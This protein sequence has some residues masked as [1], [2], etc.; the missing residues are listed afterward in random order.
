VANGLPQPGGQQR[1]QS[2]F[3]VFENFEK[4][5]TQSIRQSLSEKELAWLENLQPIA[6]NNLTT[7]PAPAAVALANI[8][9][10]TTLEFYADMN[11]TD[12]FIVFNTAGAAFAVNLDTGTVNNF[13]ASGTFSTAPDVTTWQASRVL[14]NDSIAG[15]CTFDGTI[16]IQQGS[17][18][19]NI[20]VTGGGGPYAVVPSVTITGGSGHGA[21]A[22]AVL[23]SSGQVVQVVLD[24]PGLGYQASDTL[25]I[26]FGTVPG[27]GA[28]GHVTMTGSPVS[29]ASFQ[30]ATEPFGPGNYPLSFSGGGGTGAA[31]TAVVTLTSVTVN[32]TAGG[33]GYTSPPSCTAASGTL[34]F[35]TFLGNQSVASIVRDAGGAGYVSPPNVTISGGSPIVQ[36]T[37]H[38]TES[39]GS[40]T[41]L[42]LDTAGTYPPGVTPSVVIGVGA[43]ASASAHVWPFIPK[44]TTLAVFQGRV[45]LNGLNSVSG[46]YNILQWTGTGASNGNVGYDDFLA[47]D[48]SASLVI[49]DA[50]LVHNITA[51]RSLNN[52]LFIM[53]DQSVK[54]IGNISLNSA[55][56]VTLF[57]ILTLSSDQGTIFAKSCISYNRLFL[58]ANPNGIFGVFGSAVQKVSDDLDGIFKLIDFSQVIQGAVVDLNNIHNA[59]FLVRY[60]DPAAGTRSIILIFTGKRWFV[61]NQG[62]GLTAIAG[63]PSLSSDLNVL[64]GSSGSDVTQLFANAA[65]PVSF[66]IQT[67]LTHHGNAVQG[68]K[69]IRAGFSAQAGAVNESLTMSLDTEAANGTALTMDLIDGFTVIGGANDANSNPINA[70]GIYLGITLTGT[71]DQF[72]VTNLICEYQENSLWKGA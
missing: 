66:K 4:M 33:S 9:G 69:A 71:L 10:T 23:N 20:V 50:D 32:L 11:G 36:A 42:V 70:S 65:A 45:W 41:S 52:Y 61:A 43:A 12:Y 47:A 31:G 54:Q 2:K 60:K 72:T 35:N 16:F 57:T 29:G 26:S 62:S 38:A 19:A 24:N 59:A 15:Y 63:A 56:N 21:A 37:A 27:S 53:G 67:A 58:F 5:N 7:V 44:G 64:Y 28:A 3:I 22:H 6:P 51:L 34:I 39:G 1:S 46:A 68:K 48:A 40:V 17:V 14:I 13:A 30:S 25:T 18:S 8:V 49:S 55:A